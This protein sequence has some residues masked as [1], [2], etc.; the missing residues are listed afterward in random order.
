MVHGV[1]EPVHEPQPA[2]GAARARFRARAERSLKEARRKDVIM[3]E[4]LEAEVAE[5]AIRT[6]EIG[7]DPEHACVDLSELSKL[8][9]AIRLTYTLRREDQKARNDVGHVRSVRGTSFSLGR[10]LIGV[11]RQDTICTSYG[12]GLQARDVRVRQ[13]VALHG[14]KLEPRWDHR[15][16][17]VYVGS[18]RRTIVDADVEA[19]AHV[20]H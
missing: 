11:D 16:G 3:T 4:G 2:A 19:A 20:H 9:A 10:L 5:E 18:S 14:P 7:C 12:Q 1:Y 6:L 8:G 15:L 13:T 17:G